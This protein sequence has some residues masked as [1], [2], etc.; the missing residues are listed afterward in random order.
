MND[1][2]IDP[3]EENEVT[4]L[5]ENPNLGREYNPEQLRHIVLAG[6]NFWGIEAFMARIPGVATTEVG[7]ANGYGKKP[8]REKVLHGG[9]EYALV[10]KV[11]YDPRLIRL[12]KII[13]LFFTI[14]DPTTLNHQGYDWGTAYRTGVYYED[15]ADIVEIEA[16]FERLRKTCPERIMVEF[17]PLTSYHKAE[18]SQQ[19]YLEKHPDAYC[20]VSFDTL[21]QFQELRSQAN[22]REEQTI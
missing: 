18:S 2:Y 11:S 16:A 7:Y 17:E 5:P 6:G 10:V 22:D 21:P 9:L 3:Y 4:T 12:G 15:E 14:I 8:T 20:H 19:Q 13:D 1:R